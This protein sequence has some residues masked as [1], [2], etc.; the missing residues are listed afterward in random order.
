VINPAPDAEAIRDPERKGHDHHSDAARPLEADKWLYQECESVVGLDSRPDC[1]TRLA[2]GLANLMNANGKSKTTAI[3]P[4]TLT[5]PTTTHTI[6]F[7]AD[8]VRFLDLDVCRTDSC[9]V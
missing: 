5:I 3:I 7:K 4:A 2:P 6:D 8:I 1:S 9:L